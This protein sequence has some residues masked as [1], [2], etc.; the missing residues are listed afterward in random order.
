MSYNRYWAGQ[1]LL[2]ED[3]WWISGGEGNGGS[4]TEIL[5]SGGGFTSYV[6]MPSSLSQHGQVRVN[7]THVVFFGDGTAVRNAYLFNKNTQ[8]F[9]NLPSLN[10]ARGDVV[11]GLVRGSGGKL[12][13]V[14]AGGI[15]TSNAEMSS[16][17]ILDMDNPTGWTA[18]PLLPQP[19]QDAV[20]VPFGD[21][22]LIVGGHDNDVGSNNIYEYD[23]NMDSWITR[24][25]KL[26]IGRYY[27]CALLVPDEV[28]RC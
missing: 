5:R 12:K 19:L 9:S 16:C 23:N 14:A 7:E 11:G 4:T 13:V 1:S 10:V 24:P 25:E 21:T 28:A 8:S 27:P 22:F 26:T 2:G 15:D 18:G 17:E 20:S 3:E 6:S